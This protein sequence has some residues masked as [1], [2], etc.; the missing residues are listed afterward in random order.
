VTNWHAE[1]LASPDG[2]EEDERPPRPA[3][4]LVKPVSGPN[5]VSD[6]TV[7]TEDR[8]EGHEVAV[9]DLPE[10]VERARAGDGEAWEVL[11]RRVYPRLLG[12]A[13]RRLDSGAAADAVA[14]AMLRAVTRIDRF[15]WKGGGFDAWLFGILRHV[16][17]DV[18]RSRARRPRGEPSTSTLPSPDPDPLDC[19]LGDEEACAMRAAFARLNDADRELLELR[20]V[21]GLSAQEV[22]EVLG[23]RPGAVRMAQVR[24]LQRLREL[25]EEGGQ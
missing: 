3:L 16:V 14:E 21:A 23:K 20:V 11:Y 8:C 22:A 13:R 1:V 17:L 24:A 7:A 12:Y 9:D 18:Q 4:H 15:V 10:L 6:V 25:Y 19:V 2:P 5:P